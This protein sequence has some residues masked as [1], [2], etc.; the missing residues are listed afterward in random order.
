MDANALLISQDVTQQGLL[1]DVETYLRINRNMHIHFEMTDSEDAALERLKILQYDI[2][3]I[4]LDILRSSPIEILNKLRSETNSI[5]MA[6]TADMSEETGIIVLENGAEDIQYKPLRQIEFLLKVSN[7]I[8]MRILQ[9]RLIQEKGILK[10][11]VSEEIADHII[12][13]KSTN[14]IKTYASILF[15]DIRNSTSLAETISPLVLAEHFNKVMNLII[16]IIYKNLGSV[17]NILGD[18]ILATF[19]YPVVYENDSL[20]AIKCIYDIRKA[21]KDHPFEIPVQYGIG[22]TTGSVFSGNIG[23]SHKMTC[24][25]LG[26]IVNTASRLQN[27]TK[28][29]KVDSLIDEATFENAR[30]YIKAQKFHGKVRGKN[31]QMNI[32]HPH[33]INVDLIDRDLKQSNDSIHKNIAEI[34]DVEFF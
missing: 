7:L 6:V 22:L 24:T 17:N 25:V 30:D 20:R 14:G 28:K 10:K 18:G 21:V 8:R 3:V 2:I 11:F 19:G 9:N 31:A 5:I 12:K 4:D 32:Y 16:D 23:N 26:D 13:E 29:A 33:E 1:N 27:L 15:F 34:G